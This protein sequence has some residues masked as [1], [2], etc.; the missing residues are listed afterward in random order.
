MKDTSVEN[1][2]DE[3]DHRKR[4]CD[5]MPKKGMSALVVK[6]EKVEL[7]HETHHDPIEVASKAVG[8][9]ASVSNC[10][11]KE[12]PSS[13]KTEVLEEETSCHSEKKATCRDNLHI[14]LAPKEAAVDSH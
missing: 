2:L 13:A 5:S 3:V 14:I 1:T 6:D 10:G 4:T 9:C 12:K 7:A 11:E 8:Y